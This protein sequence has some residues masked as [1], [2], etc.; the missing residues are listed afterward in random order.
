MEHILVIGHGYIGKV[1]GTVSP[2]PARY[3]VR[4]VP[5]EDEVFFTDFESAVKNRP[6][7]VDIC[8]PNHTHDDFCRRALAEGLPVYCEKPMTGEYESAAA[9]CHTAAQTALPAAVAFNYRFL[10][11][12]QMLRNMLKE[13][14]IGNILYYKASFLHDSYVLPRPKS[15]K[16]EMTGGGAM[17]DLGIHILDLCTHIFGSGHVIECQKKTFFPQRTESNEYARLTVRHE[18]F[19]GYLEISR[20][21]AGKGVQSGIEVFGDKGSLTL[22]FDQPRDLLCYDM[23]DMHIFHP[24]SELLSFLHYPLAREDIGMFYGT[25]RASL[26]AF[27]NWV[28]TGQR[29]PLSTTFSQAL[30]AERLLQEAFSLSKSR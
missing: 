19:D 26:Y 27:Y 25:H 6:L 29:H 8:T 13:Q 11:N 12:V 21:S 20:V 4:H 15:W 3:L 9:L 17:T 7:F 18:T 28:K 22:F 1:H 23:H 16:T 14:K 30:E 2:L 10:P 24:T 5:K